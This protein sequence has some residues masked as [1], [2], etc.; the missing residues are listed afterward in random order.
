MADPPLSI[1]ALCA[2]AVAALRASETMPGRKEIGLADIQWHI[3]RCTSSLGIVTLE[4]L[5]HNRCIAQGL[6]VTASKG[7]TPTGADLY[8]S[9]TIKDLMAV[10]DG[11]RKTLAL[12][13]THLIATAGREAIAATVT[14]LERRPLF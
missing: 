12:R 9:K 1:S 6:A 10:Q 13:Q 3:G 14:S 2:E 11:L 7:R 4:M 5:E 8:D